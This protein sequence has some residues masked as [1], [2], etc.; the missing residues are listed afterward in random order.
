V[1]NIRSLNK[2]TVFDAY[3]LSFQSDVIVFIIGCL[4]FSFIDGTDFFYQWRV[5]KKNRKKFTIISRRELETSNVVIIRFKGFFSY[6][7]RM[8]DAILRPHKEYARCY[9][10]DIIIFFKTY[11]KHVRHF[12]TV[13][14][15][16]DSM[17][18]TLK[19][20]KTYLEYPS[21]ILLG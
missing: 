2:V 16:F 15:L 3:P 11:E 9:I 19:G 7:Q 18:F 13:F 1:I 14:A 5:A 10:D 6:V 17:E 12:E 21:I 4:Y 8:M 20:A